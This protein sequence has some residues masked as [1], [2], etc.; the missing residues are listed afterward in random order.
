MEK[1]Q[2]QGVRHFS[3]YIVYENFFAKITNIPRLSTVVCTTSK[4]CRNVI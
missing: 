2:T 1:V 4:V 3:Y